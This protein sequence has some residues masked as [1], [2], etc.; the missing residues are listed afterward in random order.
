MFND[1][2]SLKEMFKEGL[3]ESPS[4]EQQTPPETPPANEPIEQVVPPVETPPAKIETP[5]SVIA[6][7]VKL[8]AINEML[9]TSYAS[10]EEVSEAKNRLTEYDSIKDYKSKYD[11]LT[12]TPIAKFHSKTIEE[13]NAFASVTGIDD[14]TII[15]AVKN[16]SATTEKDP[17][18]ALVLAKVLKDPELAG[19]ENLLRKTIARQYQ[20]TIPNED[21][22]DG[23]ELEIARDNAELAKFQLETD[24]KKSIKEI[25]EILAKVNTEVKSETIQQVQEQ[26][27]QL[28]AQWDDVI[29]KN[30]DKIFGK[31]PITVPK[32][33]DK[34]GQ[35]IFETIDT[36]ELPAN[37]A[38]H[39]ANQAVQKL[40]NSG[41]ELSEE[42][43]IKAVAEQHEIAIAK[44]IG[45]AM[46]KV[47]AKAEAEA[48]LQT[49]KE[50][51]NPSGVAKI[52]TAPPS[53]KE[54]D[55][56]STIYEKWNQ[57]NGMG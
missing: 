32:G 47:Q 25:D 31:I 17:I 20:T 40:V 24:A 8:Q 1:F 51:H 45:K 11:E 33:K 4:N 29:V 12:Q 16:F 49:A 28:K 27:Q 14:P 3:I 36:L 18:E 2:D 42:N 9:G 53:P 43:L 19:K 46:A 39:Y 35:E 15:R 38:K 23:E 44:N 48:K 56:S 26:K 10:L 54:K 5:A 21:E 52:E 41:L 13:I 55:F 30:V 57:M 50:V 37:E 22:L 7:D 34:D 6:D